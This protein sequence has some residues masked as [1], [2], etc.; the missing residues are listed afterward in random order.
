MH[1]S[2]IN[3]LVTFLVIRSIVVYYSACVQ[4]TLFYLIVAPKCKSS[5][6]GQRDIDMPKRSHKVLY[7]S[8]M[9]YIYIG[10]DV[11]LYV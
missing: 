6:A 4:V 8:K 1:A 7:L 9:V 5:D 3:H 11:I 10:K 2:P